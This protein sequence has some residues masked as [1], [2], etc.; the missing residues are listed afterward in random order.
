MLSAVML[1]A[2]GHLLV[3]GELASVLVFG[4]FMAQVVYDRISVSQRDA[5]G[6]LGSAQGGAAQARRTSAIAGGS[7]GIRS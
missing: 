4:S 1:W 5:L 2:L 3:N 6:P 7:G